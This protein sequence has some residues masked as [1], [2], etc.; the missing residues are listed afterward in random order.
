[1][2]TK[3]LNGPSF[4]INHILGRLDV[5]DERDCKSPGPSTSRSFTTG[6]EASDCSG[7]DCLCAPVDYSTRPGGTP[8]PPPTTPGDLHRHHHHHHNHHNRRPHPPSS[9]A[10]VDIK[11][12][13]EDEDDDDD[14]DGDLPKG[15]KSPQRDGG[16]K[17]KDDAAA[18]AGTPPVDDKNKK[19]NY[20][21]NALIMMA[22]SESPQKR[23][24]L[25]GI[26]EYIMN[27]FPFYRM[28]TP[29]W[30]NSIRHNLSLNKCFVKIPRSFDDPGKGNYWMIDPNSSD[31]YIGGTT[32]KLRRRST[33]SS[34]HRIAYRP[35]MPPHGVVMPPSPH[36]HHQPRRSRGPPPPAVHPPAAGAPH[37][38]PAS[39]WRADYPSAAAA[40]AGFDYLHQ[41]FW[42]PSVATSTAA[43]AYQQRPS[44]S[45]PAA[46]TG[47]SIS[48]LLRP[49]LQV[50][51]KRPT[52]VMHPAAA[53]AALL[54]ATMGRHHH[55]LQQ[56]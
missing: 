14:G 16:G 4:T 55:H 8:S 17:G 47:Y 10:A 28:N 35:P 34:R 18:A 19:P 38:R 44:P 46:S 21:Y 49:T 53:G 26:Y 43:G 1:M 48:Q 5:D 29:A 37:P 11:P 25:S 9:P 41:Y 27:K 15:D 24:T 39:G 20:S 52:A 51:L 50:P 2:V 3:S 31:V 13:E 32:G 40:A 56:Q 30:Q 54:Q 36:H 12:D 22:I 42:P 7:D 33:Q 45:P 23:L 6:S